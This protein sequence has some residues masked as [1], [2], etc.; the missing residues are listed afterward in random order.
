LIIED[1][2][3]VVTGACDNPDVN[4]DVW[5]VNSANGSLQTTPDYQPAGTWGTITVSGPQLMPGVTYVVQTEIAGR[6]PTAPASATL[7]DYGDVTSPWGVVD[8]DDILCVLAGFNEDYTTCSLESV[9]LMPCGPDG[10]I[11]LDDILAVL[12]AFSEP[13]PNDAYTCPKPCEPQELGGVTADPTVILNGQTKDVEAMLSLPEIQTLRGAQVAV[14]VTGGTA[15]TLDVESITFDILDPEFVFPYPTYSGSDYVTAGHVGGGRL[16]A[17]LYVGSVTDVRPGYLGTFVFRASPDADGT[18][19]VSVRLA[20]TL[21]R[22]ASSDPITI[23]NTNSVNV[24]V[25]FVQQ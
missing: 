17:G 4:C 16:S 19:T 2:A 8:L 14:D 5:Y 12:S 1:F 9:D 15:G 6:Y 21:L 7:W 10:I 13:N 23:D 22:D 3:L 11:D 25:Y 18:F 24:E 20:D